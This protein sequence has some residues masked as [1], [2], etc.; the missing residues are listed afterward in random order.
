[1]NVKKKDTS[2]GGIRNTRSRQEWKDGQHIFSSRTKTTALRK[3]EADRRIKHIN[4]KT[5]GKKTFFIIWIF[6]VIFFPLLYQTSIYSL[7]FVHYLSSLLPMHSSP[8]LLSSS[9]LLSSP[10]LLSSPR[11][12]TPLLLYRSFRLLFRQTFL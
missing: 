11:P 12:S 7:P 4:G 1:M 6:F 9:A 2:A 8:P 10:L 3:R 5:S